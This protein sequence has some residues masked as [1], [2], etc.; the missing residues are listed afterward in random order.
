MPLVTWQRPF[1][2]DKIG[3]AYCATPTVLGLVGNE[4]ELA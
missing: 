2:F 1:W 4:W 3:Q